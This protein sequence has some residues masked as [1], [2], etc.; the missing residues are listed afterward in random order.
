MSGYLGAG[1]NRSTT[2]AAGS[3]VLAV[4]NRNRK[5]LVVQ[6]VSDTA[7]VVCQT[8]E[9]ATA[10][11]GLSLAA[12]QGLEVV[13]NQRVSIFCTVAGKAVAAVEY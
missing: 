6:N 4:A 12:G 1:A 13:T 3:K 8:G 2:T 5:G 11:N 9:D 10:T 7:V